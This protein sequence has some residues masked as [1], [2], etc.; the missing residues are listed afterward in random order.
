MEQETVTHPA[1]GI[2]LSKF[3]AGIAATIITTAMIG[4]FANLWYLNS[5]VIEFEQVHQAIL[6]PNA[7]LPGALPRSEFELE[8][9]KI[10]LQ[11]DNIND[12]LDRLIN[13]LE[14]RNE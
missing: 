6:E 11:L 7:V 13:R 8:K 1:E 2:Y 12:K 14:G 5:K 4:G 9:Q 10:E 3:M